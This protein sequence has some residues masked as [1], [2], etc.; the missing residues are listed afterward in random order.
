[1]KDAGHCIQLCLEIVLITF[2]DLCE[3]GGVSGGKRITW[4]NWSSGIDTVVLSTQSF[5][6]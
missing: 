3:V 6:L 2:I 1:M 4:M 5:D